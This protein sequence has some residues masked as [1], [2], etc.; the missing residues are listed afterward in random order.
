MIGRVQRFWKCKRG[1]FCISVKVE[2]WILQFEKV[3]ILT[4]DKVNRGLKFAG[5][6]AKRRP[7]YYL[8]LA[9]FQ[10]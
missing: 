10:N 1:K 3:E 7:Q 6:M 5:A 8:K 2:H 4:A 9:S